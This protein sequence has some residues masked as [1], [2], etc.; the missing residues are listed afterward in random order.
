MP[1]L[2]EPIEFFQ[3]NSQ[4][5]LRT[6]AGAAPARAPAPNPAP[7]LEAIYP[8]VEDLFGGDRTV[9]T[10]LPPPGW[11]ADPQERELADRECARVIVN[12]SYY[13]WPIT[14]V[15]IERY[16]RQHGLSR[17]AAETE[18]RRCRRA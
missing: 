2:S 17:E 16:A 13:D 4:T 1:T 3:Q 11:D 6:S 18:I 8:T 7:D 5:E 9:A 15:E 10:V 14:D 12:Y